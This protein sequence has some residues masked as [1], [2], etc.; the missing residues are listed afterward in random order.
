MADAC[1][2]RRTR[3][4]GRRLGVQQPAA[5]RSRG[6]LQAHRRHVQHDRQPHD[7]RQPHGARPARARPRRRRPAAPTLPSRARSGAA[8]SD[9]LQLP[10]L[11]GGGGG[12]GRDG[13]VQWRPEVA[14]PSRGGGGPGGGNASTYRSTCRGTMYEPGAGLGEGWGGDGGRVWGPGFGHP[15]R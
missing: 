13:G 10:L 11:R 8:V 6:G 1:G 7:R 15:P 9:R 5:P 2:A 4:G 12:G 14:G 3:E